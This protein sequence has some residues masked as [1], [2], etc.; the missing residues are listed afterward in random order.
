MIEL[1]QIQKQMKSLNSPSKD[2]NRTKSG[3]VKK[4]KKDVS[5]GEKA[6]QYVSEGDDLGPSKFEIARQTAE[7]MAAFA[8]SSRSYLLFG[9]AA[10]GIYY[11]GEYA[12]I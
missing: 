1:E 12:S 4:Q 8:V 3:K 5:N 6:V 7:A 2:T 9:V 10:V 11:F